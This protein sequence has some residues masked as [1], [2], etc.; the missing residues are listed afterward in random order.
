MV[1]SIVFLQV[2]VLL[3]NLSLSPILQSRPE[4]SI[5]KQRWRNRDRDMG[6]GN[7]KALRSRD[8]AT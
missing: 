4:G 5:Q 2:L 6:T 3:D 8:D 7:D 1:Y